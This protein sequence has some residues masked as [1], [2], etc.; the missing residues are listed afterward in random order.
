VLRPKEF[1]MM[2]EFNIDLRQNSLMIGKPISHDV[3]AQCLMLTGEL[4]ICAWL[5][6]LSEDY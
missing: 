2:S 1:S 4:T 5:R 6:R 3:P